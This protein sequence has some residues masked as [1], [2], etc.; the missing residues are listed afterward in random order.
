[1]QFE[2]KFI[3]NLFEQGAAKKIFNK[4]SNENILIELL[5]NS[6]LKNPER[7]AAA[8][9]K[10]LTKR[11]ATKFLNTKK[12]LYDIDSRPISKKLLIINE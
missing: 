1:M 5:K 8:L 12:I 11:T 3:Q 6:T 2:E 4:S 10:I 7:L 9:D